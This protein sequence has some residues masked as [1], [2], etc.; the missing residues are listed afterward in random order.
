ML[1]NVA[2]KSSILKSDKLSANTLL[3]QQTDQGSEFKLCMMLLLLSGNALIDVPLAQ[4][5]QQKFCCLVKP[6]VS[7]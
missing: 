2:E 6:F 1:H 7:G 3:S 5:I 4:E